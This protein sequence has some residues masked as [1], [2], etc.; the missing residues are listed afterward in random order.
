MADGPLFCMHPPARSGAPADASSQ[1]VTFAEHAERFSKTCDEFR[2]A[3]DAAG[4][5]SD[6][7]ALRT[8]GELLVL[9]LKRSA[10]DLHD[11]LRQGVESSDQARDKV[12][13]VAVRVRRSP[14]RISHNQSTAGK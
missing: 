13:G 6:S 11:S 7:E 10:R 3:C 5:A 2:A 4:D 12:D 14:T 8:Q 9:E 1:S